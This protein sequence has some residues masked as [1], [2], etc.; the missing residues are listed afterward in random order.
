VTNE[1]SW[2]ERSSRI[3]QVVLK[4]THGHPAKRKAEQA[5]RQQKRRQET[6]VMQLQ[7]K[8]A[9][10][11]WLTW[12][13][14]LS[15]TKVGVVGGTFGVGSVF[16]NCLQVSNLSWITMAI[17]TSRILL[18]KHHG[19]R[20][21]WQKAREVDTRRTICLEVAQNTR[22]WSLLQKALFLKDHW[23]HPTPVRSNR[24]LRI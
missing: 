18:S 7:A 11:S 16:R 9:E 20:L 21:E 4:C 15:A 10:S 14:S 13:Q 1:G 17:Q 2:E 23:V 24:W 5:D 3:I 19:L 6:G 22:G 8:E 12:T